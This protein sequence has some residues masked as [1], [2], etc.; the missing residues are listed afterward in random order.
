[1]GVELIRDHEG[2][3]HIAL[4][5][6][7]FFPEDNLDDNI[8]SYEILKFLGEGE[9]SKSKW[10]TSKVQSSINNKL[11]FM[12]KISIN[13]SLGERQNFF[14][15]YNLIRINPHP[16]IIRHLKLIYQGNSFY[17][18]DEA[19][20]CRD[21]ENYA[22]TFECLD[23]PIEEKTLLSIFL[24]CASGLRF[25]HN[26]DIIHRNIKLDNFMIE[27]NKTVK[28]GN[29]RYSLICRNDKKFKG[30]LESDVLF[31]SPEMINDLEYGKKTDI[32]S[33][34]VV[35]YYLCYYQYPFD[36][37]KGEN[38]YVLKPKEG[39][40]NEN[41]YSKELEGIIK[42]MLTQDE[43]DR[44]DIN[45]V[46]DMIMREYV[47]Y[48]ENNTSIE[49]VLRCMNSYK[50]FSDFMT[51]FKLIYQN[52]E[53]YP[54]ASNTVNSFEDFGKNKDKSN[55]ALYANNFRNLLDK[56][57]QIDNER[58]INPK[59]FMKILLEKLNQETSFNNSSAT[60]SIQPAKWES[61]EKAL[62]HHLAYFMDNYG[63]IISQNFVG[64]LK[65]KR[66]CMETMKKC[67]RYTY[68]LYYF[69]E[70]NLDYC[71]NK[72]EINGNFYYEPDIEKIFKIQRDHCQHLSLKHNISCNICKWVKEQKEFKQYENYP[73]DLIF[74]I[75]RGE[76]YS[77][78]SPVDYKM[79]INSGRYD[80][81]GVIKRMVDNKGEYFI[82]INLDKDTN[83][84]VLYERN[85]LTKVDNP[86]VY[87]NGLVI[88]L[89]YNKK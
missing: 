8:N 46:Y 87:P 67:Q 29:F 4:E 32:F 39:K 63:S 71:M 11:Y 69:I 51:K 5:D 65:T 37:E 89:F 18:I 22:N 60:F 53:N 57:C 33:L 59:I 36:V 75:N 2:K 40:K 27:D 6:E 21:L 76:G 66:M 55:C 13:L 47:K 3:E 79:K 26:N 10:E 30:K 72:N 81:I 24:Q 34:G 1:M 84:W 80:L 14:S 70:F 19:L 78:Q 44:P 64:F 15:I 61:K 88:M 68:Y 25:I 41:V 73:K 56:N 31:Q 16:N 35:F 20:D 50:G 54:F 74:V 58:E 83:E 43:K 52:E 86:F 77:N 85:K 7:S 38:G 49:A 62:P 42:L 45:Q 82:S 48:L 9:N 17:I 28:L 12:K 23:R